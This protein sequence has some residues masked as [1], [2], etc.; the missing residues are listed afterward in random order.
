[1]NFDWIGFFF[2][3]FVAAAFLLLVVGFLKMSSRAFMLSGLLMILPFL[4][5]LGAEN[6]VRWLALF[7]LIPITLAIFAKR[8]QSRML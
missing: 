6:W 8:R 5:F 2:W 3:V 4:Y 1:M 7:P